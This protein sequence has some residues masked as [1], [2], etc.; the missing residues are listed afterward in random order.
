MRREKENKVL[1]Q[2]IPI[3]E[4]IRMLVFESNFTRVPFLGSKFFFTN[5]TIREKK[6]EPE[7]GN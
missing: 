4:D 5:Y 7:T 6:F 1:V 3:I 2:K